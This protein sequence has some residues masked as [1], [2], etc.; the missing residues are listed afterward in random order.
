MENAAPYRA[1]WKG[2][3]EKQFDT[4]QKRVR[5][6]LP[7]YVEKDFQE[8]GARDYRLDAKLTLEQFTQI[9]IKQ[10]LMYNTKH[11]LD[12]YVRDNEM[13][14]DGVEPV[15]LNLWNWGIENRSGKLRHFPETLVRLHLLPQDMATV[16]HKG[17]TFKRML[18]S[19]DRALREGWFPQARAKGAWKIKVSYDPRNVSVIYFWDEANRA[20]EPCHLLDHQ[21]RYENKTLD[22]VQNLLAHENVMRKSAEHTELQAEVDFII[23]VESI[24]TEATKE[25][26]KRKTTSISKSQKTRDIKENRSLE[27]NERRKEEAFVEI[28]KTDKPAEVGPFVP[29]Q[30]ADDFSRPS[31]KDFLRKRKERKDDE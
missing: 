14:Q 5:P 7:G 9:M 13:V 26:G 25:A 8:R 29:K 17:I 21:E 2:I 28:P 3:V 20:F 4:I 18:Y 12:H 15:P 30:S 19:T 1:D 11:Y 10:V 22:E 24:V 31:I 23:D 16:T 6:F 27:R